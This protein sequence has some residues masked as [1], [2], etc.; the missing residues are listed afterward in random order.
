MQTSPVEI[1]IGIIIGICLLILLI[2]V[3]YLVRN[4]RI[5]WDEGGNCADIIGYQENSSDDDE[6]EYYELDKIPLNW[7]ENRLIGSQYI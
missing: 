6:D 7:I 5:F 1:G 4:I 2:L 3:I